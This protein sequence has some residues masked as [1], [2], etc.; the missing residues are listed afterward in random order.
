M[1]S[2][3][4]RPHVVAS[5]LNRYKHKSPHNFLEDFLYLRHILQFSK[6]VVQQGRGKA[7]VGGFRQAA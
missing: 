2:F 6:A 5:I 7:G 1:S 3:A 4:K